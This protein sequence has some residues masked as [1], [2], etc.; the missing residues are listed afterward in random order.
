MINR[1]F[2]K[3]LK[4]FSSPSRF[5]VISLITIIIYILF[6]KA[7]FIDH[8]IIFSAAYLF[9]L[10]FFLHFLYIDIKRF[11]FWNIAWAFGIICCLCL[12]I[13]WS[14]DRH[15]IWAILAIHAWFLSL[16]WYLSWVIKERVYFDSVSYFTTWWYIFTVLAALAYWLTLLW[17]YSRFPFTC[18][19]LSSASQQVIDVFTNPFKIWLHTAEDLKQQSSSFFTT[20]SVKEFLVGN[21]AITSWSFEQETRFSWLLWKFNTYKLLMVDQVI[22]D[23]NTVNMGM[24][25]YLLKEIT[26]RYADPN[27]QFS[28]IVLIF[29][30]LYPFIRIGFYVMSF[31]G[32]ALFKILYWLKVYKPYSIDS[33]IETIK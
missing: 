6:I 30:L 26:K 27:F 31:V 8:R 24:C 28:L 32:I 16:I 29:L 18:S 3:Y 22:K 12:F 1:F 2:D 25:D 4:W 11:S 5:I 9:V 21:T 33:K 13:V 23:K 19:D 14:P 20:V 17:L 7:L 10:F 15:I